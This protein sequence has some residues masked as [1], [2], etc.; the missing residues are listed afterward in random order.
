[1]RQLLGLRRVAVA[2]WMD[3]DA[4]P[5]PSLPQA[6]GGGDAFSK[7]LGRL[8]RKAIA[9]KTNAGKVCRCV[10]RS[11]SSITQRKQILSQTR[12]EF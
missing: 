4:V 6:H 12:S 10:G 7:V 2:I 11:D 8:V 3:T 1:M 9:K 5:N